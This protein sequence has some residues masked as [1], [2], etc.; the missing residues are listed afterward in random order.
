M[1]R[2]WG[3]IGGFGGVEGDEVVAYVKLVD[4]FAVDGSAGGEDGGGDAAL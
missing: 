2:G 3:C 1:V 4:G